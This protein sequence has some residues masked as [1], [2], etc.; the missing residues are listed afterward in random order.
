MRHRSDLTAAGLQSYAITGPT[1]TRMVATAALEMPLF[2]IPFPR[3]Q[4]NAGMLRLGELPASVQPEALTWAGV[5][6]YP[7]CRC[8]RIRRMRYV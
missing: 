2:V 5:R 6:V 4:G 7:G 3:H 8:R 1:L